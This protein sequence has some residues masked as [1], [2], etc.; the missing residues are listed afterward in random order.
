MVTEALLCIWQLTSARHWPDYISFSPSQWRKVCL[1]GAFYRGGSW[2]SVKCLRSTVVSGR[3]GIW[4]K[5]WLVP[6]VFRYYL[7]LLLSRV[8]EHS[9]SVCCPGPNPALATSW[10]FALS[11]SYHSLCFK[12]ERSGRVA[13]TF[14]HC[15]LTLSFRGCL[16][17]L[18]HVL[19]WA[20]AFSCPHQNCL[21]GPFT[22]LV[23][24][25]LLIHS[26]N[27]P[28]GLLCLRS[29][30][31]TRGLKTPYLECT[32]WWGRQ[33]RSHTVSTRAIAWLCRR[34]REGDRE[35]PLQWL[36]SQQTF[37]QER[38]WA[39]PGEEVCRRQE[40]GDGVATCAKAQRHGAV[41]WLTAYPDI[42]PNIIL[43]VSVRVF[44]DEINIWTSRLSKQPAFPNMGSIQFSSVAQSC[45][46]LCN[47]M[48]YSTQ[49][50][51]VSSN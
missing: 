39:A 28:W 16:E 51:W 41:W 10:A 19:D 11:D 21:C 25:L 12:S 36:E 29:W 33:R 26:T 18:S 47:S 37:P 49:R 14:G 22:C 27:L 23:L 24:L 9:C 43:D 15:P 4:I 34:I 32:V 46:T 2:G 31:R 1:S 45:P 6:C 42:W 8:L 5:G 38:L 44:L 50:G 30:D 13:E 20:S 3:A 40:R 7:T 48:D 17:P 35:E